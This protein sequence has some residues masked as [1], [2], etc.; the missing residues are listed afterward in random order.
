MRELCLQPK[1]TR[2]C[3]VDLS[4]DLGPQILG[5]LGDGYGSV[6]RHGDLLI[7]LTN[8]K[9]LCRSRQFGQSGR[10]LRILPAAVGPGGIALHEKR[11]SGRAESTIK[12]SSRWMDTGDKDQASGL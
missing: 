11:F 8:A 10:F 7:G 2:L 5:A 6:R 12:N 1:K 9:V 3:V 4:A